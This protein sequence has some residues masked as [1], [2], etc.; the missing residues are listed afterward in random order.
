MKMSLDQ[1]RRQ[2]RAVKIDNFLR[3]VVADTNHPFIID[4]DVASVDLATENVNDPR[5]SKKFLRR[6]FSARNGELVLDLPH[7]TGTVAGF[8]GRHSTKWVVRRVRRSTS[9]MGHPNR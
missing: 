4:R 3:L 6:L 8:F 9:S 1:A 7:P 5:V 2:I